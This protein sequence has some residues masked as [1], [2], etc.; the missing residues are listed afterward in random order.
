MSPRSLTFTEWPG[1]LGFFF[2]IAS[3]IVQGFTC[4]LIE[5]K[6]KSA[7]QNCLYVLMDLGMVI[8]PRKIGFEVKPGRFINIDACNI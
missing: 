4:T 8:H 7:N 1:V 6:R 3:L 5:R 2:S